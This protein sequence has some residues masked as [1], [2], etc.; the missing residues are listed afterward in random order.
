[1][2]APVLRLV[3]HGTPGTAGSK[4]AFPIYKGSGPER[5]FTGRV[6]VAE[7]PSK[8]KTNWRTAIV[9]EVRRALA[10]TCPAPDCTRLAPP[11][12]LDEALVASIVFTVKK[13]G[14]APKRARTWPTARPDLLKYARATEDAL[15]DAGVFVDDA[16][17]VDY[18]R[19]AKVYPG[20]DPDALTVPGAVITMWRAADLVGW[21][22]DAVALAEPTY[23]SLFDPPESPLGVGDQDHV[24]APGRGAV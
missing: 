6:A 14:G 3:V 24:P 5:H 19:L 21:Q 18:R 12:P 13:P 2:T 16:R 11:F 8:T 17:L 1:M 15:K 7:S 10:C 23:P 9:D 22:R 20:E 4:S